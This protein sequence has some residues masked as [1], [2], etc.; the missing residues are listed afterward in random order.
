[1]VRYFQKRKK[2]RLKFEGTL[3]DSGDIAVFR[4]SRC[5]GKYFK[6]ISEKEFNKLER[7]I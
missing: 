2:H 7:V 1:M 4:D 6:R 5:E 3:Y